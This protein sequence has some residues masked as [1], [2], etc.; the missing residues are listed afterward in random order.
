MPR[1]PSEGDPA[2]FSASR[3]RFDSVIAFLDGSTGAAL[4]HAEMEERLTC[5]DAICFASST[6]TTWTYAPSGNHGLTSWRSGGA[7]RARV[8][9]GVE[10]DPRS[11]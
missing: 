1:S 6:R 4:S 9:P 3:E 5:R 7:A 2:G 8:E 11:R 10:D